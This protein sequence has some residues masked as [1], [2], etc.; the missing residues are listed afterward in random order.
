[1]KGRI[2]ILLFF[3]VTLFLNAQFISNYGIK[4]GMVSSTPVDFLSGNQYIGK[5]YQDSRISG[6]FSIFTQF[7]SSSYL[8]FEMELGYKQEG[9]EDKITV[10]TV[11][12][13]DGTDQFIILDHAYDF[14]TFNVSVQPKYENNDV[15]IFLILSPSL[16]FMVKNRDQI[17]L[18]DDP[19]KL[20]F[21]YSVGIGFQPKNIL[22]G[23]LFLEVKYGSSF[24]KYLKTDFLEG[25]FRTLQLNIGSYI[26]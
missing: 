1:M 7:F 3:S 8:R 26:N 21:A 18:N 24:S 2:G 6:A 23:K 19:K 11:D 25:E 12:N 22:N 15:C 4:I 9:A 14:V 20:V 16:N 17:F 10:T 5:Y 13:P